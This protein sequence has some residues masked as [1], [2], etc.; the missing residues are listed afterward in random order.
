MS[1]YLL[2]AEVVRIIRTIMWYL[3]RNCFQLKSFFVTVLCFLN[4]DA[5]IVTSIYQASFDHVKVCQTP[6]FLTETFIVF[7]FD[8]LHKF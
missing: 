2:Y 8:L 1:E 7:V 4:V 6:F 3:P 5:F